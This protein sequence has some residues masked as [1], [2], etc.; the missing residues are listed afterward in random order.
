MSDAIVEKQ[1]CE[2]WGVDRREGTKFCYSCGVKLTDEV[3][4]EP[5]SP[6]ALNGSGPADAIEE[7]A[8]DKPEIPLPEEVEDARPLEIAVGRRLSDAAKERRHARVVAKRPREYTWE[9]I[10]E[11]VNMTVLISVAVVALISLGIVLL[12]VWWK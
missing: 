7:K 6:P 4:L 10:D 9:P 11:P 1:I 5:S 8:I 3:K 12:M 2:K